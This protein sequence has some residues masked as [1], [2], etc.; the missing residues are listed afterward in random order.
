M[1]PSLHYLYVDS[2]ISKNLFV[3]SGDS[4]CGDLLDR[5]GYTHTI[6]ITI[7]TYTQRSQIK[8]DVAP[9]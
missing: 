4:E 7:N 6:N 2:R 5:L 8:D 3:S 1:V 9:T